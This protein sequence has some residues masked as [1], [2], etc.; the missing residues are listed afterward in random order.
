MLDDI[1]EYAK[2]SYI[3]QSFGKAKKGIHYF[4]TPD[5]MTPHT[6]CVLEGTGGTSTGLCVPIDSR[7]LDSIC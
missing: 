5:E 3:S 2:R 7:E 1:R 6:E 4:P